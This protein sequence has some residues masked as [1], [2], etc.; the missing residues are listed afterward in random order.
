MQF[1]PSDRDSFVK[2]ATIH[3]RKSARCA[4]ASSISVEPYRGNDSTF[5]QEEIQQGSQMSDVDQVCIRLDDYSVTLL[6]PCFVRDITVMDQ[7][8]ADK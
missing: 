4:G 7:C 1:E 5:R 3:L 2:F 8:S 6:L